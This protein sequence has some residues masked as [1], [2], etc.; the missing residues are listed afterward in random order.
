M[1]DCSPAFCHQF[2]TNNH[3]IRH[4]YSHLSKARKSDSDEIIMKKHIKNK[5]SLSLITSLLLGACTCQQKGQNISLDG[6]STV[7]VMSEA[8]AEEYK[9]VAHGA[10]SIGVSGTGGGFKKLC[11]GRVKIIGA[12]RPITEEEKAL[13]A[14]NSIEAK[15]FAVANDGIVIAVNKENDWLNSMSV[16]MLKKLFEPESEGKITKWSDLK[17]EWPQEKIEI[18]SP[19]ISSGSYDYFTKAIVGKEHAS[20]GDMT[21][22]EDDNVLVHG[23]SSNKYAIGFFSFPYYRENQEKLKALALIDETKGSNQ[24][25]PSKESIEDQ[26]YSPLSRPLYLYVNLKSLNE[27]EKDFVQ[28]Y[29][30]N[31]ARLAPEL[32]FVPLDKVSHEKSIALVQGF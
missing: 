5:L 2:V 25:M 21:T 28:F 10:V 15:D 30:T 8:V 18:F 6:S 20:R 24:V 17:P 3:P 32:G 27:K 13:C 1:V 26:S 4:D 23:V 22:S 16:S 7:Y 14:K 11:D 31:S 9:K 19:G 29:I 12:S